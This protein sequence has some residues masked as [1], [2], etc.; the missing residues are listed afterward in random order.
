MRERRKK[1]NENT[2]ITVMNNTNGSLVLKQGSS[3]MPIQFTRPGEI[4]YFP[5]N[6]FRIIVNTNSNLFQDLS[7]VI[8]DIYHE[9]EDYTLNDILTSLRMN[10]IYEDGIDWET[11]QDDLLTMSSDEYDSFIASLSTPARK[12]VVQKTIR[13]IRNKKRD[14]SYYERGIEKY[15]GDLA[16]EGIEEF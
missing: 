6:E 7:L 8:V 9:E 12:K 3:A 13:I 1:I 16:L 4:Q 5:Y 10:G 2:E 15:Y 11:I 14:K